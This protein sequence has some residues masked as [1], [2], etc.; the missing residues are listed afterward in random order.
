MGAALRAL[1]EA[2]GMTQSQLAMAAGIS[3]PTVIN[4]ER[5]HGQA[6]NLIRLLKLLG[7]T[8]TVALPARA[9]DEGEEIG[10]EL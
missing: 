9:E 8:I 4:L 7:A 10:I 2:R 6:D 5:G 1:R 3:R